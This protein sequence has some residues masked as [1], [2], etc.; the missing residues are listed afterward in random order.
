VAN[1]ARAAV[2]V[3]L[4]VTAGLLIGDNLHGAHALLT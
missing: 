2:W 4:V 3:M 1:A